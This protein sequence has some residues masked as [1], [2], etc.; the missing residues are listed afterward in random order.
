MTARVSNHDID[1][2]A[3]DWAARLD[4]GALTERENAALQVWLN[5]DSRNQGAFLRAQAIATMSQSAQALGEGFDPGRFTAAGP[6]GLG[7]EMSPPSKMKKADTLRDP[8][9]RKEL[10]WTGAVAEASSLAIFGFSAS[11]AGTVYETGRGGIT[12]IPLQGV[13]T[14]FMH[15]SAKGRV[16]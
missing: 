3:A 6:G 14:M 8:S 5:G 1:Q 10:A 2:A 15:T 16:N 7:P 13:S 4:R 12:I 9:R 11:D